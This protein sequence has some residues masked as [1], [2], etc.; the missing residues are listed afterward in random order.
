VGAG[1]LTSRAARAAAGVAAVLALLVPP[2]AEGQT[3]PAGRWM[4]LR[5][6]HLRVHVRPAQESLGVRVAGEAEAAWA[7][8]AAH[9][10]PPRRTVDLVVSDH[11]DFANGLTSVFPSPRI[12]VYPVPPTADVELQRYDRWLRLLLTHEL[13]HVFHLDLARGWWRLGRAVFGRAPLLFPNLYLPT[14]LTEGLAVHYESELTGG[15]RDAGSYHPAVVAAQAAERGG[16]TIDAANATSPRW[17]GGYRPYAFGAEFLADLARQHGEGALDRLAVETAKAPLPYLLLNRSVR[18]A[19][20]VSATEAWSAWQRTLR[21]AL[22]SAG[23]G[24]AG[25][26]IAA[27][28]TTAPSG[29]AEL[30]GLR[31]LVAPRISPDGKR[32]LFVLADGVDEPRIAVLDRATGTVRRS[33]RINGGLGVAWD[34]AGGVVVSEFEFT[35]PYALRADLVRV[36]AAGRELRLT[37]GERL[38][39]PDVASDGSVVAV[40]VESGTLALVRRSHGVT[41]VVVPPV[42]RVEWAQPRVSPDGR[43]IAATRAMDGA[44]DVV[45]LSAEG[46]LL[47]EVTRDVAIDQMPAFSPDGAWLFWASDRGGRAELYATRVADPASAWWRVTTE[48]FGAYTPAPASD[49]VFYLAYHSGGYRLAAVAFDTLTWERVAGPATGGSTD[50]PPAAAPPAA[51]AAAVA[52]AGAPA[53]AAT[54]AAAEPRA[55]PD[56]TPRAAVLGRHGYR[57]WRAL[58]PQY[59]LPAGAAQG[60]SGWFGLYTSGQDALERHGYAVSVMA[61]T[62][63]AAGTWRGDVAYRYAGFRRVVL[64]AGVSRSEE[65]YLARRPP[66]DSGVV[67]GC[68]VRTD[69]AVLGVTVPLRRYR[70]SAAVRAAG[71]YRREW[72]VERAGAVLSAAAGHVVEPAFAISAQKGWRVAALVRRR[73]RLGQPGGYTEGVLRGAAYLPLARAGFAR[74][75]V[76][77]HASV[78]YLAGTDSVLFGVGGVSG[79]SVPL[80]PGI[81]AGSSDR[82]FPVRGFVP[83]EAVGR[84]AAAASAEW[85]IPLALVGRGVGLVPGALDRLSVAV[86]ADAGVAWSPL[87]WTAA[88]AW[89]DART[90]LACAGAEL[91]ADLGLVYDYP[92]RLRVGWAQ[93]AG[94]RR[95]SAS[96]VAVGA[97]F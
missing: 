37:R 68:C 60:R 32:I 40:Q 85:R 77:V 95:G 71:E 55:V 54:P 44:L 72:G 90:V 56:S 36:D 42:P 3:D 61:G 80:L 89:L 35:D 67:E 12:I 50:A 92:V 69:E 23:T 17:P 15:G 28:D 65:A 1:P 26:R 2:R 6:A 49:S 16:L 97:A 13:A 96:F 7:A 34:T 81:A 82:D 38:L 57:P 70:T 53:S 8:L 10:P 59:W 87:V 51:D 46:R 84:G 45:L 41:R 18:R 29:P 47:R 25:G 9:L 4:T 5:T 39:A 83:G 78:G 94:P 74:Q 48:P 19:T 30:R 79:G 62:G 73:W 76:A 11:V 31:S 24:D 64:D 27:A 66:P 63:L 33:A 52:A 58:L 93:R 22:G 21:A 43:L 75:V 14:W 88:L 20:A 91:V 86:F